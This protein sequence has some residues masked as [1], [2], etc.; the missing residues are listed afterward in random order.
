MARCGRVQ[1]RAAWPQ[2][3]PLEAIHARVEGMGMDDL[4]GRRAERVVSLLAGAASVPLTVWPAVIGLTTVA[5][6]ASRLKPYGPT[7]A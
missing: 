2:E 1:G 6:T 3:L 5:G 4:A 7:V